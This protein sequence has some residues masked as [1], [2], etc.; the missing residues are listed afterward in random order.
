ME[1][2]RFCRHCGELLEDQWMHCPW[3]GKET[4]QRSLSWDTIVDDSLVRTETEL[5]KGRMGRLNDI[6]GKLDVL[7]LELD[8]FLAD[9]I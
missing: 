8:V 1:R 7:E 2:V 5:I 4:L 6:S 9:K 3:C